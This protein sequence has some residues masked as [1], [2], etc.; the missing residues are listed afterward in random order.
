MSLI[1]KSNVT[2]L[3]FRNFGTG[4]YRKGNDTLKDYFHVSF[5]SFSVVNVVNEKR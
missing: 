4:I 2:K 3:Q 1:K 5:M